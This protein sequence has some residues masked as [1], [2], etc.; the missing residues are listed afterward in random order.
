MEFGDRIRFVGI[1]V[2]DSQAG[3]REFIAEFFPGARIEHLFDRTGVVPASMGGRWVPL[4]FFF[5]PGGEEVDRH[6]GIIDERELALQI[7]EL[8]ARSVA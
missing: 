6:F 8:L 4:T 1:N 2:R 5:A 7:D 3:A